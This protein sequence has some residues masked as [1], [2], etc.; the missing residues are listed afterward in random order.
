MQRPGHRELETGG[1]KPFPAIL[2]KSNNRRNYY[3][4]EDDDYDLEVE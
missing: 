4:S 3:D 1:S 2:S